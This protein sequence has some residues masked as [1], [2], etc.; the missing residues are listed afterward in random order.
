M[1]GLAIVVGL[2]LLSLAAPLAAPY[3]PL[4]TVPGEQFQPPSLAHPFGT[5]QFGR[6]LL[7]RTIWGGRTSLAV[8][9]LA[10]GIAALIG[11]PLGLWA[12]YFSR[13]FVNTAVM[14]LTDMVLAFPPILLAMVIVAVLGPGTRSVTVSIAIVSI[15]PLTR[16]ARA[17]MLTQLGSDYVTATRTAGASDRHIIFRAI[18][19]NCL[20]PILVQV[21]LAAG[22][23]ILLEAALSF[24]G[25]GTQPPAPS[26]GSML[27]DARS[28]LAH[29]PWYGIFPGVFIT[30]LIL[31]LDALATGLRDALDPS[32][33]S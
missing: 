2:A 4:A 29:A 28:Y 10:V 21:A 8:A 12:G 25:L 7:S 22:T 9:G 32:H 23:A 14:R 26:W 6:D 15:P 3:D 19:P 27:Y 30:L 1:V 20:P 5:D 18:L 33:R 13:S 31:G 24:L 16:L 17:A 11:F